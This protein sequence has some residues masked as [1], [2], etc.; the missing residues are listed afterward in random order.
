MQR[1]LWCAYS[2]YLNDQ[3][4]IKTWHVTYYLNINLLKHSILT[5]NHWALMFAVTTSF[6]L[7]PSDVMCA[8][9]FKCICRIRWLFQFAS[10]CRSLT[11]LCPFVISYAQL[12]F[13]LFIITLSAIPQHYLQHSNCTFPCHIFQNSTNK[14]LICLLIISVCLSY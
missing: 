5:V 14:H 3:M 9:L 1:I 11:L 10:S 13:K 2:I 7:C 6:S 8:A 4:F 12:K